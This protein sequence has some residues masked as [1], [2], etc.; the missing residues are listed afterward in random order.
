MMEDNKLE[1]WHTMYLDLKFSQSLYTAT[2]KKDTAEAIKIG[3]ATIKIY[4]EII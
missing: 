3:D 1:K 4:E 2:I